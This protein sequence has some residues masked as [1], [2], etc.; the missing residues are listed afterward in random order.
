MTDE[1]A[2][3]INLRHAR[4]QKRRAD[5]EEQAAV[6]R[7]KFGRSKAEKTKTDAAAKSEQRQLD[8]AKVTGDK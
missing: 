5:K 2:K 6:N 8:G 1:T 7:I 4:K 3:I